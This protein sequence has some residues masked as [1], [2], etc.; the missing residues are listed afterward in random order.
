M[1]RVL[2]TSRA[3]RRFKKLT[4]KLRREFYEELKTLEIDPFSHSNIKKLGRTQLGWRLRVGR[5]RVLFALFKQEKRIEIVDIFLK[6]G[7]SDYDK[8]K[9]LI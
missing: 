8:R 5:W 7:E 2:I 1:F 4:R 3:E 6:K 9:K